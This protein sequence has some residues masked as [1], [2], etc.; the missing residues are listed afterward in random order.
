[1]NVSQTSVEMNSVNIRIID[2]YTNYSNMSEVFEYSFLSHT[3]NV[4]TRAQQTKQVQAMAKRFQSPVWEF[5]E[6]VGKKSVKC[7][8]CNPP[9]TVLRYLGGTT[10]MKNHLTSHH[11]GKYS[12]PEKDK[13][14]KT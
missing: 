10:T 6:L 5:F 7:K 11:P 12:D 9:G 1:M 14:T 8:L 3:L 2:C 4:I 13:F